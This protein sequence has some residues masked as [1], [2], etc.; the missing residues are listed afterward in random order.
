MRDSKNNLSIETI[1]ATHLF[2]RQSYVRDWAIKT[3]IVVLLAVL[4]G[5]G[6]F[7]KIHDTHQANLN[8]DL[9]FETP[10]SG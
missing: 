4:L 6:S 7:G 9:H 8:E 2:N 3:K 5:L 1:R 10:R